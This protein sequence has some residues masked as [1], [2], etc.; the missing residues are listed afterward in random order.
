M[1]NNNNNMAS[2]VMRKTAETELP[3]LWAADVRELF[4][5]EGRAGGCVSCPLPS[6][7][8]AAA[9]G[10]EVDSAL[11]DAGLE[12]KGWLRGRMPVGHC[13]CYLTLRHMGS[14]G[15]LVPGGV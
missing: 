6:T 11:T 4:A 14:L 7:R 9:L 1:I 8:T 12:Q 5:L 13:G 2:C 3:R 10:G 15:L